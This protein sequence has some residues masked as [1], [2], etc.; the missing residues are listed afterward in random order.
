[1]RRS[2][3]VINLRQEGIA[4]LVFV[5]ILALTTIS[6]ML[7]EMSISDIRYEKNISTSKALTRAKQA[8]LAYAVTYID[9]NPGEFGFLPCPDASAISGTEGDSDGSCGVKNA[10]SMGLFPW[11]TLE[12]GVMQSSSGVCLWYAVSGNYKN[13]NA[14]TKT[15]MLNEDTNGWFQIYQ[16]DSQLDSEILVHGVQ[17]EDRVIA[18]IIDPSSALANQDRVFDTTS[19]CGLNDDATLFLE[20][21]GVINNASIA[22]TADTVDAFLM[23][24]AGTEQHAPPFNDRIETITL[25]EIWQA[26]LARN[27]FDAKMENL[28]EALAMCLRDY[29]AANAVNRLPWP[30]PTTLADYRASANYNDNVDAT[31]GYAGRYPFIVDN[32]N[33]DIPGANVSS[34]L[35]TEAGCSAL[36]T[37]GDIVDLQT[38]NSEYR[39]LWE[40]WKDHFFYVVSRDYAP[41]ITAA[42]CGANCITVNSQRAAMVVYAGSKQAGQVRNGPVGGDAGTKFDVANY[43]ENGNEAVFPDV[44]G[45]GVYTTAGTGEFMFCLTAASPPAVVA[46]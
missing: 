19:L 35:F 15:D 22:G 20:G 18:V 4:L 23:A 16:F 1:M 17:P 2:A 41:G 8:L 32:S 33:A 31:P 28:T 37:S 25:D 3:P 38:A 7:R 40:N 10:N 46:C 43:M 12:T 44:A 11:G 24:G 42:S 39:V 21:N 14:A 27:T 36:V 13:V 29:A 9:N 34:E 6:L 45:N 26:V 30:A 5:I